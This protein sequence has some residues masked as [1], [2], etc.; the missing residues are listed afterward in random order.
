L[1]TAFEVIEH[2]PDQEEMIR[3]LARALRPGGL[4]LIS[5]PNKA[6][7]SDARQYVNPFHLREFYRE[8]FFELLHLGFPYVRLLQ[9]Q[10]R[11]GSLISGDNPAARAG[12]VL[13]RPMPGEERFET[14][15]MFFLACCSDRPP[16]QVP[17]DSAY[18]D[19]AD[20]LFREWTRHQ[21]GAWAEMERLNEEIRRLGQWGIELEGQLA[22][23]D[24]ALKR[25]IEEVEERDRA[26]ENLQALITAETTSRD[27]T[28]RRLQSE[29]EQEVKARDQIIRDMQ[30]EL[31]R[32]TSHRDEAIRKLQDDFE[33]RTKWAL[34]LQEAVRDRDDLL[35]KTNAALDATD[36]SLKA[37]SEHL[38]RIRH[39]FLYRALCRLG[40]LPK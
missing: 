12:E 21:N 40:I 31:A 8:E 29:I 34:S 33:E 36:A 23:K 26:L 9:Q 14:A 15:P 25:V 1:I 13:T 19:P 39:A 10:I 27:E 6:V 16:Q 30:D 11:A 2:V 18:L 20:S 17:E 3:E 32:E 5:T 38:A 35:L 28:I 4:A 24:E 22:G 7:Y 37:V